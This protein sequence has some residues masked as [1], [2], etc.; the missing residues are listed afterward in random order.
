M[1]KN[2]AHDEHRP[3]IKLYVMVFAALMVLTFV[4]VAISKVHLPRPQAI[5]L[6]LL[7]ATVKASLVAAVFMLLWGEKKLIS[8]ILLVTG[9][10]AAILILPLLDLSLVSSQI[11]QKVS[12]AEQHPE[13]HA[14]HAESVTE[15]V[16]LEHAAPAAKPKPAKAAKAK[17]AKGKSAKKKAR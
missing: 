4:T 16:T 10:C 5:A 3:N 17:P 6:G 14:A 15:T 9:A 8:R 12:V 2:S 7:V 11:T 13:E 1:A